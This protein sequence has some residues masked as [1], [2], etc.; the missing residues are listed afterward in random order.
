MVS[1][2]AER[3]VA[4][5][6]FDTKPPDTAPNNAHFYNVDITSPEAIHEA[7]E[8]VRDKVGHPTVL[9]N[10]AG[11]VLGKD[12]LHCP[13]D[14]IRRMFDVNILSHFWLVQEFLPAMIK[15]QHGHVVTMASVAS[16]ITIASNIDYSCTKAGLVAFYEGLAQDLKHRYNTKDVMTSIVYPYWVRT[17]L[18]QNLTTHPSFKDPLLEPEHIAEVVVDHVV[19]GQSGHV[20]LPAHVGLLSGIRGFP[21]WLQE[22]VRD[23]KADVL[24]QT[25]F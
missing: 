15:A 22:L 17:P 6:S 7:A 24:R 9:I 8:K 16:F 1:K 25:T 23:G 2:F 5:I 18:I 4:V 12:I 20:Y 21:L 19:K 3:N 14:H 11:L 10:N 13:K